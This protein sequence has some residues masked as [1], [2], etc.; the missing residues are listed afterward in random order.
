M[1]TTAFDTLKYVKTLEKSG[2][3]S[4][5]AEAQAIA[6]SEAMESNL[7]TSQ[8]LKNI[9]HKIDSVQTDLEHKVDSVQTDLTIRL[10]SVVALATGIIIAAIKYIQ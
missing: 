10:Y 1:T 6:L 3:S 2:I 4:K 8:D 9:E 7:A 5:Q